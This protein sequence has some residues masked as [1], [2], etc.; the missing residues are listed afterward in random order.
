ME[1]NINVIEIN[2]AQIDFSQYKNE[3][4]PKVFS[5]KDSG[6]Y[7]REASRLDSYPLSDVDKVIIR[8][9]SYTYAITSS[10]V[11]G[12][13][14]KSVDE[15]DSFEDFKNKFDII[16][17]KAESKPAIQ[18]ELL[19]SVEFLFLTKRLFP[20]NTSVNENKKNKFKILS[21]K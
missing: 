20:K 13:L 19:H 1:V 16:Y 18:I 3:K 6:E 14:S 7:A 15:L 21:Y 12:L 17:E 8:V 4:N 2:L 9:P 5:G 10:F 11:K